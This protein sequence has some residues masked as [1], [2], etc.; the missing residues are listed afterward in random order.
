MGAQQHGSLVATVAA[1]GFEYLGV[2]FVGSG[3][4]RLLGEVQPPDD[5]DAFGHVAM[6]PGHF[7]VACG[8]HQG[9]VEFLVPAGHGNPIG[10]ALG[11]RYQP[12]GDQFLQQHVVD[13]DVRRP[14]ARAAFAQAVGG[15]GFQHHA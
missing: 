9:A 12:D 14:R 7:G 1:D 15:G 11:H 10:A 5:A 13:L 4:A 3:N 8:A 2:L 6:H